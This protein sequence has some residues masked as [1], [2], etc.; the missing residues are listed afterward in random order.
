MIVPLSMRRNF[1]RTV[2]DMPTGGHFG[3]RRTADQVQRRAYWPGRRKT[4]EECC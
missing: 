2:H 3:R 1:V 4:V